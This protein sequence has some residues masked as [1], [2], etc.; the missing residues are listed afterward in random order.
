MG[1]QSFEADDKNQ[2]QTCKII[3]ALLT[4]ES[5]LHLINITLLFFAEQ[6]SGNDGTIQAV[7]DIH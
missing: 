2:F 4:Y 1:L 6:F 7:V 5:G 3:I